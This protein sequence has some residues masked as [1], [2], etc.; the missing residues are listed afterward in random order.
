MLRVY[1]A[2][3][4]SADNVLD[5]LKNIGR[6]EKACARMFQL[7]FSPFCPWHDKSYVT[8]LP[9]SEFKVE[10]F[11]D[12]SLA[13]LDVSDVMF[14]IPG[15]KGS[16]VGVPRE[17]ARAEELGI[18]IFTNEKALILWDLERREKLESNP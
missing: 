10:Q 9:D 12:H 11:Q 14:L 8:D 3:K 18:P 7:G 17:I 4:Y 6:G 2:G 5:V 16:R 13:W 15:W 1:V